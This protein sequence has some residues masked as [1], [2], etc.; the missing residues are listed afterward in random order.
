MRDKAQAERASL[1]ESALREKEADEA[2]KEQIK[3]K[4]SRAPE[5]LLSKAGKAPAKPSSGSASQKWEDASKA[6]WIEEV[7]QA[8]QPSQEARRQ[9]LK[10]KAEPRS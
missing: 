7:S 6:E 2:K 4:P 5:R 8:S 10:R 3:I 1:M 9:A